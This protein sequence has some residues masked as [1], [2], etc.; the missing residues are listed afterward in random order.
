MPD[1]YSVNASNIVGG[2][3]R[4][5]FKSYDGSYP[6][7]IEDVMAITSPYALTSGWKDLG[8]TSDG[9]TIS[10]GFDTEDFSVDQVN[11]P[12]DTDITGW[13]HT[14]ETNL[15][16]NTVE[17]RQL[18]LIGGSII[19]TLP[20]LGTATTTSGA[21]ATGAT[22]V[23]VTSVTGFVAGGYVSIANRT[24]QIA[25]IQGSTLTLTTPLTADLA[26]G[27]SVRPVTTLGTRRI[28]YGTMNNIPFITVG[29]ISQKKDGTLYMA[30][31][32]KC[33]VSGD[34]KEQ[35]FGNEK[36]LLP[37]NLVAYP[38]GNVAESENVYFEIE[39]LS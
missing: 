9:I 31:F 13:S 7:S 20:V 21:L 35:T 2:P 17:N 34:D 38:D 39:Q 1:I 12:V 18:A 10:R 23:N 19:E 33:K 26:S 28:G 4:L 6:D 24:Y 29:L 27:A 3:G 5:V 36:R 8:A 16:E 30:V 15:A 37:L 11:G 22:L 14:L 32:R 25:S